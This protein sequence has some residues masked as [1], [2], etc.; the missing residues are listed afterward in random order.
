MKTAPPNSPLPVQPAP[1]ILDRELEPLLAEPFAGARVVGEPADPHAA[2]LRE[3][4]AAR[5]GASLRAEAGMVTARARR[6]QRVQI[7]EGVTTREL[8]RAPDPERLRP[9]EPIRVALIALAAGA[10]YRHRRDAARLHR[11]WLVVSGSARLDGEK[12]GLRDYRAL[13]AGFDDGEWH[14]DEGASL[15]VRESSLSP[16]IGD[17]PFTV[18]D[19]DA[20]WADLTSRIR[21]RVLWQRDGQAAMLYFADP[22]AS[23]P[24]HTHGHDEEC[25]MLQGEL[26]LDDVLL[27]P[28]DYQIAPAGGGHRITETDT[29][30]VIYA[31][32][33]LNLHFT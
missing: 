29:G 5:T 23:V 21:R 33:D 11:E 30:A 10:V 3:K 31:H 19:A 27:Q 2:R 20:G 1:E 15:F 17:A 13:P 16:A 32:G 28:G 24:V 25:L 6:A 9:G 22:G 14:S 4:L 7:G 8:Y 18:R 12:L 26:F